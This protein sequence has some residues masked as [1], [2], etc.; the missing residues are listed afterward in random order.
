MT[1]ECSFDLESSVA[2]S[3]RGRVGRRWFAEP[4]GFVVDEQVRARAK[5]GHVLVVESRVFAESVEER[6]RRV[7]VHA[8]AWR[9][10][11]AVGAAVSGLVE[12][13]VESIDRRRQRVVVVAVAGATTVLVRYWDITRARRWVRTRDETRRER[14][15]CEVRGVVARSD[16]NRNFNVFTFMI[17]PN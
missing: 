13:W 3:V 5:C 1:I 8:A 12:I 11:V 7:G 2:W 10:V 9:R 17:V 4:W 16:M 14:R 15:W 6:R